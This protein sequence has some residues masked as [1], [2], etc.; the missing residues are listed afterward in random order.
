ML[1]PLS[2]IHWLEISNKHWLEIHMSRFQK[3]CY[4]FLFRLPGK[5]RQTA[6]LDLS[7]G[8]L[9]SAI[10]EMSLFREDN[11]SKSTLESHSK[12]L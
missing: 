12:T 10:V 11:S 2:F 5:C 4:L 6:E 8:F 3:V 7:F 1:L 9:R